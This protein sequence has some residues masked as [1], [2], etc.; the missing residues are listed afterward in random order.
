M[1]IRQAQ[2][3]TILEDVLAHYDQGDAKAL[4]VA[5]V[6]SWEKLTSRL[7]PLLGADSV[8]L[9]YRRSL[10]LNKA[11]YPWLPMASTSTV[12]KTRF[13]ELR[14]S[15]EAQ[16]VEDILHATAA[17]LYTFLEVLAALI[18]EPLTTVF[19]RSAFAVP[20][21]PGSSKEYAP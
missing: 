20:A 8:Y 12:F 4:A 13:N 9:I 14:L 10:D 2:W 18:G 15:L 7:M 1:S 6:V 17:L 11:I 5:A 21:A 3:Q 16:T 19:L